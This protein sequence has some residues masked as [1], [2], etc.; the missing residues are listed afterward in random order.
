MPNGKIRPISERGGRKGSERRGGEGGERIYNLMRLVT[1][2][3]RNFGVSTDETH[4][5]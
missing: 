4:D 1:A 2:D 5:C 3:I